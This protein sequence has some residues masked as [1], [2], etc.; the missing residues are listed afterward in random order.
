MVDIEELKK[1]Y[2]EQLQKNELISKTKT[3]RVGTGFKSWGD[4]YESGFVIERF[5]QKEQKFLR[6]AGG[7]STQTG[8]LPTDARKWKFR[9]SHISI[10]AESKD[11]L[12]FGMMIGKKKKIFKLNCGKDASA[13]ESFS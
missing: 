2:E 3:F 4:C 11:F 7:G 10:L 13:I 1:K 6:E 5:N 12:I 8:K 9:Y